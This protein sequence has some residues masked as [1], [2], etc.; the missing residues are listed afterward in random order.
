MNLLVPSNV[1]CPHCWESFTVEVDTT[2][3]S[4]ETVEDCSVC[5]RP[6]TLQIVCHAG[7][8]VSIEASP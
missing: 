2:Q 3:G 6:M 4:Y 5:C 7:E 8:V 1:Q